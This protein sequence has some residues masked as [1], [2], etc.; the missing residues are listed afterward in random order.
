M[1]AHILLVQLYFYGTDFWFKNKKEK[2]IFRNTYQEREFKEKQSQARKCKGQSTVDMNVKK[3]VNK[4]LLQISYF[5][6]TSN[7]PPKQNTKIWYY[8]H[9]L[10]KGEVKYN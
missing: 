7:F 10:K 1:G 6:T 3:P 8:F 9:I 2:K 5:G 4:K